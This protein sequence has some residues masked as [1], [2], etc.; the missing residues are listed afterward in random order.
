MLPFA[1]VLRQ[2]AYTIVLCFDGQRRDL[3]FCLGTCCGMYV[4]SP[5][6][7]Q[8]M[9]TRPLIQV[10][11]HRI[12]RKRASYN[13]LWAGRVIILLAVGTQYCGIALLWFRRAICFRRPGVWIRLWAIDTRNLQMASGG[14]TAVIISLVIS[15]LNTEWAIEDQPF[16]TGCCFRIAW[17]KA[18]NPSRETQLYPST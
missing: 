15:F 4:T 14:L 5:E 18:E 2:L 17:K 12:R 8:S 16:Y 11:P 10:Y 3:A 13:I 9:E 1:E 6:P 7:D